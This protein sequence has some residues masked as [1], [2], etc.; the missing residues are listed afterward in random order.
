MRNT[1][2]G[3]GCLALT[4]SITARPDGVIE[5]GTLSRFWR[6]R[7]VLG[8]WLKGRLGLTTIPE[9]LCDPTLSF[10]Y[11]KRPYPEELLFA[12]HL[13]VVRLLGGWKTQKGKGELDGAVEADLAYRGP[14]G[15]VRYRWDLLTPRLD[16]YVH[17]GYS[18][19]IVLDNTPW[20][21]PAEPEEGSHYGQSAPPADFAEWQAFVEA[22]C[23]QLVRSYGIET[24]SSW[25]FRMGT[26][27]QGTA[28]FGGTQKQFHKLY[29]HAAAAVRRVLPGAAFGPFNLAGAPDGPNISYHDL[30]D[31]CVHGTNHATGRTG[32]P[33]D[34]AC[35]SVYTA[36]SITKGILRTTDPA[37]KARQKVE[38][39]DELAERH[40]GLRNVS[41]EVHEFGILGSEFGI[42]QGEPGARGAAW[43]FCVMV[44]LLAGGLDRL[45]HWGVTETINLGEHRQIL[46][47]SGWLLS[48]L[49][50][51]AGGDAYLLPVE[52]APLAPDDPTAGGD[53]LL[54]RISTYERPVPLTRPG[55]AFF[56]CLAVV[57]GKR[58]FLITAAYN[59]DRFV[60]DPVRVAANVPRTAFALDGEPKVTCAELTRTNALYFRIRQDLD[61]AGLLDDDFKAVPGLLSPVK[62]MGGRPAWAYVD[63]HWPRYEATIKRS[64]TL[65]PFRGS[66]QADDEGLRVSF[67]TRPPSMT[68]LVVETDG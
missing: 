4:P 42:G 51:V 7:P 59:E 58:L 38:F 46:Q 32:S 33:L 12:D 18:L 39:W 6:N 34:L 53:P 3:I 27:C 19:T 24:V 20:C 16:H 9:Y 68:V 48:V 64:L 22:L 43:Q 26:E 31:H 29:D 66:V 8:R 40:A 37:F 30:V 21:F 10:P 36:P 65:G 50:H 41:R 67:V 62:T 52:V 44:D 45:W 49:E 54:E 57:K 13:T 63:E 61:S 35:V 11:R 1:L 28:R 55:R 14:D 5:L 60:S 56:R 25:R 47:S 23:H 2:A 17:N 15:Q